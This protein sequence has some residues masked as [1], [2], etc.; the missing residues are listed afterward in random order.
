[1]PFNYSTRW[2]LLKTKNHIHH[3]PVKNTS[4]ATNFMH[5]NILLMQMLVMHCHKCFTLD[6]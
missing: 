2:S 4:E 6:F 3:T 1:M 5:P